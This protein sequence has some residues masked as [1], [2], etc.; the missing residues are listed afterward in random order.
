MGKR[1]TGGRWG[2]GEEGMIGR[3]EGEGW[4]GWRGWRG[5]ELCSFVFVRVDVD[6]FGVAEGCAFREP[7]KTRLLGFVVVIVVASC[8]CCFL[9]FVLI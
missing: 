1:G 3:G 7:S 5:W 6:R 2:K 8:C 4:Q 9:V